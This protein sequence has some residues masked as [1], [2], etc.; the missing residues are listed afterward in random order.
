[1][2]VGS[3]QRFGV[4]LWYGGPHAAFMAVQGR[5]RAGPARTAGR[6]LDRR[7]GAAR[8]PPGPADPRAAHPPREGDVEHLHGPGAPRRRGRH[9]RRVPRRRGPARH[10]PP[11]PPAGRRRWPPA[12]ERGGLRA[13]PPRVLRHRRRRDARAGPRRSWRPRPSARR[14]RCA[15][16]TTTTSGISCGETTTERPRG[17]CARGLRRRPAA[18][19]P[20]R[21]RRAARGAAAPGPDPRATRSSPSTTPRRRCCATCADCPTADFALDRGMIPLGS[22]TMKLNATTE[23]EP[24]GLPGFADVH[25]FAPLET[26]AG[27]PGADRRA[28]GVAGRRD[29]ATPRSR[30][31]RTPAA[32]ASWPG[33][34]PSAPT[35]ESRGEPERDVCLI[36]S[37][38]HGTNAASAVMAGMR[39]VVVGAL[40]RRHGRP[41]RPPRPSARS[42][43]TAWPRSW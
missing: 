37:S 13:R 12:L 36:P 8:L 32:R 41:R 10:R 30:C 23:M 11:R 38:A 19:E 40:Q 2:V 20:G 28:R 43:P 27:L 17:R 33:C 1:M 35:T 22:C 39:V 25:P 29:R 18:A 21:A 6:P 31:S 16:S 15:W 14:A 34:W 5:A 3:S 9:V 26:H 42:T 7:R 4:P 24:V